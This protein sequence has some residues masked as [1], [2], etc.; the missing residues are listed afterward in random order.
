MSHGDIDVLLLSDPLIDVKLLGRAGVSRTAREFRHC[1]R[2]ETAGLLSAF[3][4]HA[5]YF[6]YSLNNVYVEGSSIM[7]LTD[8][9]VQ[10]QIRNRWLGPCRP[11]DS[12][13]PG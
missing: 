9:H 5:F 12:R 11:P 7:F 13:P 4:S 10:L 8:G 1:A 6:V 3:M 2:Y